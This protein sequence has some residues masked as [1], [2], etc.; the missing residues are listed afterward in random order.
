MAA[1]PNTPMSRDEYLAF[2]R[3]QGEKYEYVAGQV[4]A[5]VG[6]SRQ[7]NLILSSTLAHL[8]PQVRQPGCTIFPSD[9]KIAIDA[10]QIYVYPDI[11]GACGTPQFESEREGLLL[12]PTLIIEILSPSTERYDRTGKFFRYQGIPSFREYLL[13]AQDEPLVEQFIREEDGRWVWSFTQGLDAALTIRTIAQ[14][15]PLAAI[16]EQVSFAD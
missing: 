3:E 7:H 15:L 14:T 5:M 11:A 13:V 2:E 4:F 10:G 6:V 9:T 16:Y 8:Y 12:N 1:Q